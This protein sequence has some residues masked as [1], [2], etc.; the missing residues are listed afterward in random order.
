MPQA[1]RNVNLAL[2]AMFL[3]SVLMRG[4]HPPGYLPFSIFSGVN[5]PHGDS[6]ADLQWLCQNHRQ[7]QVSILYVLFIL[8]LGSM[9]EIEPAT[10]VNKK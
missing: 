10:E 6:I 4:I 5:A 1:Q 3:T 8:W 9:L 2:L 7:S